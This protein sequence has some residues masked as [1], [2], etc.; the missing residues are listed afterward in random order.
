MSDFLAH[1]FALITDS[2]LHEIIL[3][4]LQVTC[5]S[6]LIATLIALP[7]GTLLAIRSF[8]GARFLTILLHALLGFPPVVAGLMVYLLLSREG[9]LGFWGLLYTPTAMIIAQ[10]LIIIP[11]IAVHCRQAVEARWQESMKQLTSLGA[12]GALAI[13][14]LLHDVRLQLLTAILAGFGRG[15]S[16][17]GAVAIVGGNIDHQTRVMTTA[18]TLETNQGNLELAMT[19]GIILLLLAL[20]INGLAFYLVRRP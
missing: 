8:Y 5:S 7:L 20:F 17:V 13:F 11:I 6:V 15:I 4:S 10:T 1:S 3:L 19:L 12:K 18:I 16:E 9:A 14:T 2:Y